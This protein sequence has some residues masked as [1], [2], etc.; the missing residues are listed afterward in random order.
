MEFEGQR[1]D[2]DDWWGFRDHSWGI[3][4]G[5]GGFEPDRGA[6][7]V[8]GEKL[9]S[10]RVRLLMWSCFSTADYSCQFQYHEDF[11]GNMTFCDGTLVY[12]FDVDKPDLKVKSIRQEVDFL[13]KGLAYTSARYNVTLSDGSTLDVRVEPVLRTWAFG[14]MGYDGSYDDRRGLGAQRGNMLEHDVLDLSDCEDVLYRGGGTAYGGHREQPGVAIV[15]GQPATG[16]FAAIL[17]K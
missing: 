6:H 7:V 16:H 13:P 12:P 4:P 3:R 17:R 2:V 14:G 10:S 5:V 8:G 9:M 11:E 1:I 15:N